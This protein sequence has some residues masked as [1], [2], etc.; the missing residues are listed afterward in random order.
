MAPQG[1]VWV[2]HTAKELLQPLGFC[3]VTW[4]TRLGLEFPPI[5][6]HLPQQGWL[7]PVWKPQ[8]SGT[9]IKLNNV[10]SICPWLTLNSHSNRD[11]QVQ[12]QKYYLKPHFKTRVGS[13]KTF[14]M[15]K[16][17]QIDLLWAVLEST[18][19]QC[20]ICA[21]RIAQFCTYLQMC[22]DAAWESLWNRF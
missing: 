18:S 13:I 1:W 17:F 6:S 12:F 14:R 10:H 15:M 3:S 4:E 2:T 20:S 9:I 22:Q 8:I 5:I 7:E 11:C 19:S 16:A 21:C